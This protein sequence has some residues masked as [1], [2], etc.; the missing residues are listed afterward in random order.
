MNLEF[1]VEVGF[2]FLGFT[3]G[4]YGKGG[5]GFRS[6]VRTLAVVYLLDTT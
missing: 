4:C 5:R 3:M 2:L 1:Q 6:L